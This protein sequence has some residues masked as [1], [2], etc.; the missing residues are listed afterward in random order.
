MSGL[1]L[2]IVG[3]QIFRHVEAPVNNLAWLQSHVE[4]YIEIALTDAPGGQERIVVWC[5]EE[6]HLKGMAPNVRRCT[7]GWPLVGPL[8]VTGCTAD[9]ENRGL[10][11]AEESRV[12]LVAAGARERP[13]I[14]LLVISP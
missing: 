4:G 14:P 12:H 2:K 11:P 13:R 9:G 5:N 7:D 1:A 8:V 6:G 10:T 3:G